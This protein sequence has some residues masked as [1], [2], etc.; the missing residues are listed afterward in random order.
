MSAKPLVS[1]LCPTYNH[2]QYIEHA[3]QSFLM[4]KTNFPFEILVHDDASTD[5]TAEIIKEYKK[6]YPETIKPILRSKN[7]YSTGVRGIVG[8]Y[9]LPKALG[10]YTATCEGDDYWIDENKLQKQ[11]DFLEKN[12]DH[13]LVFHPVKVFYENGEK[14]DSIFPEVKSGFTIDKLLE[15]NFIQTNSVMYRRQEY[16]YLALD[17]MPGD[18][19]L[20]LYHAQFGKIGFIDE[21]MS[22]YRRHSGGIWWQSHRDRMDIWSKHGLQHMALFIEMYR[23]Y[24]KNDKNASTIKG[25]ISG[26]ISNFIET[27]TN[28]KTQLLAS[29]V[30]EFPEQIT[31]FLESQYEIIEESKLSVLERDIKITNLNKAVE[32][33]DA[34][35]EERD[36]RLKKL[37]RNS[38]LSMGKLKRKIDSFRLK[39]AKRRSRVDE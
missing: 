18:Y 26:M 30:N 23:L 37:D 9:L 1:I 11:V 33:R 28:K 19:Y 36:L 6:K 24:G 38:S 5:G 17:V 15:G 4:Q 25:L 13:A 16:K 21:V 29:C 32:R 22:A 12:K 14:E 31:L 27:D 39:E 3:L 34:A 10:K 8:R 35:I 7:I 2:E 20:H